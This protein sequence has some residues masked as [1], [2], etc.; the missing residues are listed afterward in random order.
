[1]DQFRI[2]QIGPELFT[3]QEKWCLVWWQASVTEYFAGSYARHFKSVEDARAWI[4]EMKAIRRSHRAIT[5]F[6]NRVVE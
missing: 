3:V 5:E 6:K 2:V 1:M 4:E